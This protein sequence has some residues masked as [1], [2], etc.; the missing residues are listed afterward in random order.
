M[1]ITKFLATAAL[2][3]TLSVTTAFAAPHVTTSNAETQQQTDTVKKDKMRFDK[4]GIKYKNKERESNEPQD[5]IK[6]LESKKEKVQA[7][8]KE[9]K[10]TKEKADEII[11]KIDAMIKKIQEFNNLTLQQKKDKLIGDFKTSV[12]K[13]VKDGKLTQEKADELIKNYTD[14]VNKWDGTGY[15]KLGK[16]GFYGK[17]GHDGHKKSDKINKSENN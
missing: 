12:D 14:K 3:T 1:K 6:A 2:I 8:L 16:R 7:Q 9:G 4:K 15:P 17:D 10:I 5:P 13:R 11:A